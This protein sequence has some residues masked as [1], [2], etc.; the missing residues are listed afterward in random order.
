MI[1][2]WV[3]LIIIA[4]IVVFFLQQQTADQL[5]SLEFIP[6]LVL[7]RPWT[8]FTY[9]FLHAD[10][11]HIFFNMLTLFF[12]GPRVEAG[13]GGAG[14]LRWFLVGGWL[15]PFAWMFLPPTV[16][17]LGAAAAV[18]GVLLG[19]A[20]LWPRA[21]LLIWGIVPVQARTMVIILTAV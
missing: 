11:G 2:K 19:F 21:Q 20:R 9:M 8:L 1:T 13:W 10:F 7:I 4:N 18:W 17:I 14:F 16:G 3:G 6:A 12:F 15:G 5:R